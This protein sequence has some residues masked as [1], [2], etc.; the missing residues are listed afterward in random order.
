MQKGDEV[1]ICLQRSL[2]IADRYLQREKKQGTRKAPD[3]T[4]DV[5]FLFVDLS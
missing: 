3:G 2:G 1:H 4:S 5:E